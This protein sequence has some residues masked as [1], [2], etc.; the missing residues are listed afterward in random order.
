MQSILQG[1]R[2]EIEFQ[3]GSISGS[4]KSVERILLT[5]HTNFGRYFGLTLTE[6]SVIQ[7]FQTGPVL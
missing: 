7:T 6:F 2:T 4:L 5:I 3:N 1:P